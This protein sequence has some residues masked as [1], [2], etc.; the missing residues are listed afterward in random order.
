V[1]RRGTAPR[2]AVDGVVGAL[3]DHPHIPALSAP[4]NDRE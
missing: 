1:V 2:A 4:G 3:L